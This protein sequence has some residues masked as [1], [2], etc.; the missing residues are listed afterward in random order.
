MIS[1]IISSK[2]KIMKKIILLSM[3]LTLCTPFAYAINA[4]AD[5]NI[6]MGEL[7]TLKATNIPVNIEPSTDLQWDIMGDV[8]GNGET[9]Y[10]YPSLAG[11]YIIHL[12]TTN[13]EEEDSVVV[14]VQ[15]DS[16]V[17][18]N[19]S[20]ALSAGEDQ[21]ICLGEVATLTATSSSILNFTW[22]IVEDTYSNSNIF[23]FSPSAIR[24]YTIRLLGDNQEDSVDVTV[25][26]C[27]E[28]PVPYDT[29][30]TYT[31]F[32]SDTLENRGEK[33][34]DYNTSLGVPVRLRRVSELIRRAGDAPEYDIRVRLY[35]K[36]GVGD[37]AQIV[38]AQSELMLQR[39]H[40]KPLSFMNF[41]DGGYSIIWGD[42]STF[43][44][45]KFD[46]EG[47]IVINNKSFTTVRHTGGIKVSTHPVQKLNSENFV[48]GECDSLGRIYSQVFDVN[49][50]LLNKVLVFE[51]INYLQCDKDLL[52]EPLQSGGFILHYGD[53]SATL[54]GQGN[55]I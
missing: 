14:N 48:V 18:D 47:N 33:I 54:D 20:V 50:D 32:E 34:Y 45:R 3:I 35:S 55:K 52:V 21:T 51:G 9:F 40:V 49:A 31:T 15:S 25:E 4:G 42:E 41:S 39:S 38:L 43:F 8:Y 26:D 23:Y 44:I 6:S 29:V 24:T 12:M 37:E 13:G 30:D 28:V 36:H 16:P 2:R 5:I 53:D 17:E 7:A 22:K 10:F 19:V 27:S 46:A 1:D 11:T